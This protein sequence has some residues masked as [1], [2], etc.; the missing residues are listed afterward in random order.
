MLYLKSRKSRN[1][2]S[3]AISGLSHGSL[4]RPQG[5][6][7]NYF[8]AI[9]SSAGRH[10]C[11]GEQKFLLKLPES[12]YLSRTILGSRYGASPGRGYSSRLLKGWT[13]RT[14]NTTDCVTA[15][16]TAAITAW[17]DVGTDEVQTVGVNVVSRGW[18]I[19]PVAA[20][21]ARRAAAPEAGVNKVIGEHTPFVRSYT[22]TLIY[23]CT[24]ICLSR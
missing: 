8:W 13:L 11:L 15:I 2:W 6:N 12:F 5:G 14:G 16:P 21:T 3:F 17:A 7:E 23:T 4:G 10:W 19:V 1:F 24:P 18:P 22:C 20:T 9:Y